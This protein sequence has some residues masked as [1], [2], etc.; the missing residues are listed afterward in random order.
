MIVDCVVADMLYDALNGPPQVQLLQD[1][2]Q[3]RSRYI[4]WHTSCIIPLWQTIGQK[5]RESAHL[6]EPIK[7]AEAVVGPLCSPAD[8]VGTEWGAVHKQT[9]GALLPVLSMNAAVH[10]MS[11][12]TIVAR[13]EA[14]KACV[15]LPTPQQ[16]H[17]PSPCCLTNQFNRA[18]DFRLLEPPAAPAPLGILLGYMNGMQTKV[19][20][21]E[22]E[23]AAGTSSW[24]AYKA[25]AVL[26]GNEAESQ[27]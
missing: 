8:G 21:R 16:I 6:L 4:E 24:D 17:M 2:E 7:W 3:K 25:E 27:T 18:G 11:W 20:A 9:D 14:G 10:A 1:D 23:L 12:S 15:W 22:H 13:W 5:F 19:A 26:K